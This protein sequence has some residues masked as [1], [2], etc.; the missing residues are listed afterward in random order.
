V[1]IF[2]RHHTSCEDRSPTFERFVTSGLATDQFGQ[3]LQG[4][5]N[6]PPHPC[7]PCPHPDHILHCEGEGSALLLF[8]TV[9]HPKQVLIALWCSGVDPSASRK[10]CQNTLLLAWLASGWRV[11]GLKWMWTG[12]ACRRPGHLNAC[13]TPV[14]FDQWW[15]CEFIYGGASA[16]RRRS[17]R[18]AQSPSLRVEATPPSRLHLGAMVPQ[19]SGK[20]VAGSEPITIQAHAKKNTVLFR[21]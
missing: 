10:P 1:K 5:M 7:T 21:N 20:S 8:R 17:L 4:S 15:R 2:L 9:D 11:V 12:N 16:V 3:D 6:A 13:S 19:L 14:G 18:C